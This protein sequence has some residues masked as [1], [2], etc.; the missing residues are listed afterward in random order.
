MRVTSN[1]K[2]ILTATQ[3]ERYQTEKDLFLALGYTDSDYLEL[4]RL[5]SYASTLIN[6]SVVV[7]SAAARLKKQEGRRVQT[8]KGYKGRN[9][10]AYIE[11]D[12]CFYFILETPL[13]VLMPN[14]RKLLQES[15]VWNLLQ[16]VEQLRAAVWVESAEQTDSTD[17][18]HPAN[19]SPLIH[20]P[21][22]VIEESPNTPGL[23]ER[24][25]RW[26]AFKF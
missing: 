13:F 1:S 11:T 14:D 3:Y 12:T 10:F 25:V 5:G 24:F 21:G 19:E 7:A 23:F 8:V 22:P 17:T 20:A 9:L 18:V 16:Q 6:K 15:P 2:V 26:L 4:Q